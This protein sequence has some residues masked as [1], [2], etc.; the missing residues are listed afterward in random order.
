MEVV[1]AISPGVS[2]AAAARL[3][4]SLSPVIRSSRETLTPLRGRNP[5][6]ASV[7]NMGQGLR[8]KSESDLESFWNARD[9][10]GLTICWVGR[11]P[12]VK[13]FRRQRRNCANNSD[14]QIFGLHSSIQ[15]YTRNLKMLRMTK[16]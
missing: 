16:I 12:N 6:F 9:G 14:E 15:Y 7:F 3:I 2:V 5:W 8:P 13:I 1:R 4:D 11:L 10:G